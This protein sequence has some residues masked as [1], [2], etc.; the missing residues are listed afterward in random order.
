MMTRVHK[1]DSAPFTRLSKS[2]TAEKP[3]WAQVG[4]DAKAISE[5]AQVLKVKK[6]YTAGRYV[7]SA[8]ALEAA[9]R[10]ESQ[11]DLSLAVKGL[12]SSCAS[13]HYGNPLR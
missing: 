9:A 10:K 7:R 11:Q 3:D 13:C 2:A 5:L 6:V 1:G 8:L 4:K 12:K